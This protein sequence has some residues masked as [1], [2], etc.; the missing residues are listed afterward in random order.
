MKQKYAPF[1]F[2]SIMAIAMGFFVSFFLTWLN[3]GYTKG[4]FM[5]WMTAFG[6]GSCV[7]FPISLTIAPFAQKFVQMLT[8]EDNNK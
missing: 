1:V 8:K 4:F 2:A 7:A 6:V 3:T 5:R